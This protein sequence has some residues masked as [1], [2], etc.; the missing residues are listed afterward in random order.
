MWPILLLLLLMTTQNFR[1]ENPP[2]TRKIGKMDENRGQIFTNRNNE[3]TNSPTTMGNSISTYNANSA[4]FAAYFK[5][6]NHLGGITLISSGPQLANLYT[7]KNKKYITIL[8][9]IDF[10][11]G[12]FPVEAN[13][14]N[15]DMKLKKLGCHSF[16]SSTINGLARKETC[17]QME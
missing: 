7:K 16:P 9:N 12:F 11:S 6:H 17:R 3:W 14:I 1:A 8:A 15:K 2:T 10:T 4:N 5:H 13:F